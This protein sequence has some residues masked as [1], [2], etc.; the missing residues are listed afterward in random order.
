MERTKQQDLNALVA[1]RIE[2][3]LARGMSNVQIATTRMMDESKIATDFIF[4]V[5]TEKKGKIQ[6]ITFKPDPKTNAI[7]STFRLPKGN[8]D[9]QI[10]MNAVR[11]VSAKLGIP[12]AYLTSLLLGEEWQRNLGYQIMNTTNGWTDRNRV[13]VRA[14]GHEVRA[15]LSDQYRRLDS[16]MIFGSHIDA[17][18]EK[19]GKLSD[20]YMSDTRVLIE[21]IYPKPIE[22][23]TEL[24]G[25]IMIAFGTR[26]ISSDY[27]HGALDLRSFILQGICLNGLVR[28]SVLRE[29]HLGA[30]L[31]DNLALSQE[32]YRLDSMT[33]ASAI[34]D[35]T[36][37]LYSSDVIKDRMLEIKASTEIIVDANQMLTSLRG[38]NKLMKGEC[39]EI[40]KILMRNNPRDGV[41]GESTLWK[42]TQGITAYA[43]S[44]DVDQERRIDLQEIAGD[45][46]KKVSKN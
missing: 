1:K 22:I 7:S 43:N 18:Y 12:G 35:L 32:T 4:E 27:G 16:E 28:E 30:K 41:Q 36:H 6:N 14:V 37:N 17:V 15:F 34:K 2:A 10:H 11:Q 38:L 8:E 40:G 46:F 33:T 20:G 23:V 29:I 26:L 42:L 13:L 24:N 21:S 3:K 44:E 9:Y 19:G 25:I 5:G 45:L 31:P 39:D